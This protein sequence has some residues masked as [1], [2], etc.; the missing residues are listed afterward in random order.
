MYELM[1]D[2][3]FFAKSPDVNL[4]LEAYVEQRYNNGGS[5][6]GYVP[7]VQAAWAKLLI[8]AYR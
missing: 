3:G 7:G 6:Q 8:G 5:M 1:T 2:M 4:W